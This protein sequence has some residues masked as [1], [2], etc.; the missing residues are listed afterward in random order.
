[1]A[2]CTPNASPAEKSTNRLALDSDISVT[3]IIT[4]TSDR[5]A[6]PM[7]FASLYERGWMV[8]SLCTSAFSSRVWTTRL[9]GVT[10]EIGRA[11]CRERVGE[12]MWDR[13]WDGQLHGCRV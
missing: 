1:M 4:G 11:S 8:R 3:L 9:I 10:G 6:S 7:S 13:G 12:G 2:P 5:I